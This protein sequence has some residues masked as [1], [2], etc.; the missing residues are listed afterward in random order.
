MN[1]LSP[2]IGSQKWALKKKALI[3]GLSKIGSHKW[4]LINRLS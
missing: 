1:R 3:N 2:K 4:A